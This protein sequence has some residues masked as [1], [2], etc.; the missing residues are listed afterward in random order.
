MNILH[1]I[2]FKKVV[3]KSLE[4]ERFTSNIAKI[5]LDFG[6]FGKLIRIGKDKNKI[7]EANFNQN[8][9]VQLNSENV[10]LDLG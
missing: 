6:L 7:F 2:A 8:I 5:C 9:D 10:F 3:L 4:I 1:D